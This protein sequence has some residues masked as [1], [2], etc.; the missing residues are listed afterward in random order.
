MVHHLLQ[1]SLRWGSHHLW[2]YSGTT[3]YDHVIKNDCHIIHR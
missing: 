3:R 1:S 2:G